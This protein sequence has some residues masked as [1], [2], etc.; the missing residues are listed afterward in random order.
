MFNFGLFQSPH[1]FF[2]I[3]FKPLN[4]SHIFQYFSEFWPEKGRNQVPKASHFFQLCITHCQVLCSAFENGGDLHIAASR[5]KLDPGPSPWIRE[6]ILREEDD[7]HKIYPS[8][9]KASKYIQHV[10][11]VETYIKRGDMFSTKVN[12]ILLLR[13]H[14][15]IKV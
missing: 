7:C 8:T 1:H 4:I 14:F 6:V 12:L 13:S 2:P 9:Q 10:T 15:T 11:F 5:T 3:N